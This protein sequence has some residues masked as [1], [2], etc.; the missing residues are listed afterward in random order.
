MDKYTRHF[1]V[2]YD[3]REPR[4]LRHIAKI[5]ESCGRRVQ[6]SVFEVE[7]PVY[8]I[9]Q[10]KSRIRDVLEEEDFVAIFKICERD[11]QKQVKFGPAEF[12]KE[13]EDRP[14]LIL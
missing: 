14:F 9:N 10:M 7:A 8:I 5:M 3:I 2:I 11:W 1:L 4:R 13:F 12:M 6:K